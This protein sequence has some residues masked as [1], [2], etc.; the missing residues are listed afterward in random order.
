MRHRIN[1]AF[2]L[3]LFAGEGGVAGKWR[4]LGFKVFEYDVIH[5]PS[6]DLTAPALQARILNAMRTKQVLGVMM[7]T[8]CTSFSVARDRT[9]VIRNRKFPWKLPHHQL[10]PKDAVKVDIG[11]ACARAT[12]KFTRA[13]NRHSIPWAVENPHSSKL[14]LLPEFER[15]ACD[16]HTQVKVVDFCAYGTPWRKR[17]RLMFGNVDAC[18]LARLDR[19][20]CIGRYCSFQSGRHFQLTGA[21]PNHKP[22]TLIAQPYPAR[23]C[24]DLARARC[25]PHSWF[26]VHISADTG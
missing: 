3:D 7:A 18:D 20:R 15:L 26:L 1:G 22:W 12:L 24:R 9:A 5:G 16:P 8:P 10:S 23:L 11:N 19:C 14:W 6:Y 17:T 2:F 4:K 13:C 21:G 25:H